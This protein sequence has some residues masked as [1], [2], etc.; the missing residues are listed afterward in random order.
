MIDQK[1]FNEMINKMENTLNEGKIDVILCEKLDKQ[2]L[3]SRLVEH[4]SEYGQIIYLLNG[5]MECECKD[6]KQKEVH[7][8][9]SI[10]IPRGMPHCIRNISSEDFLTIYVQFQTNHFEISRC[11]HICDRNL[12]ILWILETLKDELKC[13]YRS[14]MIGRYLFGTALLMMIKMQFEKETKISTFDKAVLYL[15]TNINGKINIEELA[16]TLFVSPSYLCRLFQ[17]RVHMTIMGYLCSM[18]INEAMQYLEETNYGIE[19]IAFKVGFSSPKYFTKKF[20]EVVG[21]T[22][23]AFRKKFE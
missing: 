18:R 14:A 10:L 17:K 12:R 7:A 16:K 22:P 6:G 8:N 20:K 15:R 19:E 11:I 3:E 2:A 4:A 9:E 1:L 5:A 23:S 13:E 21:M